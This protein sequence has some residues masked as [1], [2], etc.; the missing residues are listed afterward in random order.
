MNWYIG[1]DPSMNSSAITY[2]SED[3]K[4]IKSSLFILKPLKCYYQTV[5]IKLVKLKDTENNEERFYHL[6]RMIVND[7]QDK[8]NNLFAKNDKYMIMIEN[9]SFASKGIVFDIGEAIGGIKR[10]LY[11]NQMKFQLIAPSSVKK[12]FL[13]GN[14]SKYELFEEFLKRVYED[15][16]IYLVYYNMLSE[17]FKHKY[18]NLKSV[19]EVKSPLSDLIDSFLISLY[20]RNEF[21]E[22]NELSFD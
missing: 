1:I 17:F 19:I 10:E 11:L 12:S 21:G 4:V 22:K 18:E 8:I 5:D 13:K 3:L 7:I 14:S 9:Y 16:D 2:L 15:K 6:S 20:S